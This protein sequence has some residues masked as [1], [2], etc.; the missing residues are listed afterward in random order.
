MN[1]AKYKNHRIILCKNILKNKETLFIIEKTLITKSIG[2]INHLQKIIGQLIVTFGG[3]MTFL[4][5]LP[6]I[7]LLYIV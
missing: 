3:K 4:Q 6:I 5:I 7:L 1:I 2:Q